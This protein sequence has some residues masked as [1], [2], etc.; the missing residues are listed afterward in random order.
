MLFLQL[1][2]SRSRTPSFQ[3]TTPSQGIS[4][5]K[6]L[7]FLMFFQSV[8]LFI[9]WQ[10]GSSANKGFAVTGFW[11]FLQRLSEQSR[12]H[13]SLIWLIKPALPLIIFYLFP[14][15][16]MMESGRE[17]RRGRQPGF[18][19]DN[20]NV[21]SLLPFSSSWISAEQKTLVF[22]CTVLGLLPVQ[23]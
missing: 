21:V 11:S 4:A 10:A 19:H 16:C 20:D 9:S 23:G 12:I 8:M 14:A 17:G 6:W 3:R 1:A 2:Q 18:G 15:S 13:L 5:I 22:T 7:S